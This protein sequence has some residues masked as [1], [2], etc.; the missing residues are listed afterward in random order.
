M[1]K[2]S[3]KPSSI[4][5]FLRLRSGNKKKEEGYEALNTSTPSPSDHS[6]TPLPCSLTPSPDHSSAPD[7]SSS[8]SIDHS[9]GQ[10]S[11]YRTYTP[12]PSTS[13]PSSAGYTPSSEGE[14]RTYTSVSSEGELFRDDDD[15]SS[16]GRV[17]SNSSRLS[18]TS[19]S[20]AQSGFSPSPRSSSG[21]SGEPVLLLTDPELNQMSEPVF[22][23]TLNNSGLFSAIK[24][25]TRA[26]VTPIVVLIPRRQPVIHATEAA[27]I[28]ALS[29]VTE[30]GMGETE[31]AS[32][33]V[34]D[35]A[36]IEEVSEGGLI[37]ESPE[38]G[39]T[40]TEEDHDGIETGSPVEI[41]DR[42]LVETE[43]SGQSTEEELQNPATGDSTADE[44]L[45]EISSDIKQDSESIEPLEVSSSIERVSENISIS[46]QEAPYEPSSQ[47]SAVVLTAIDESPVGPTEESVGQALFL[48]ITQQVFPPPPSP[49]PMV[50]LVFL[51]IFQARS[52]IPDILRSYQRFKLHDD[53]S[54]S[55]SDGSGDE[56]YSESATL[57]P[58]T[59]DSTANS[60]ITTSV[61][62][63]PC[64]SLLSNSTSC[65]SD[66]E[67]DTRWSPDIIP[68]TYFPAVD[69]HRADYHHLDDEGD[70]CFLELP[71]SVGRFF[72]NDEDYFAVINLLNKWG[73]YDVI[74]DGSLT[75]E[76]ISRDQFYFR[77]S[78]EGTTGS[79]DTVMVEDWLPEECP[80]I[81]RLYRGYER[82]EVLQNN[83]M[84]QKSIFCCFCDAIHVVEL[85]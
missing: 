63:T 71:E 34:M 19:T 66:S 47:E 57:C 78:T 35:Y 44:E 36:T 2:S 77:P 65:S 29:E 25:K 53:R 28:P 58:S 43:P 52:D 81:S 56:G 12:S 49:T 22:D 48:D 32:E 27:R 23:I 42:A 41:I 55:C 64:C 46:A 61:T 79:V 38:D 30:I 17:T 5:R 73:K 13:V 33:T 39:V 37:E 24:S 74:V 84:H 45:L 15:M 31:R 18:T 54:T 16:L 70:Y 10:D 4:I 51:Q 7:P 1:P 6:S 67:S 80:V 76:G 72:G 68:I 21:S 40:L 83:V 20:S 26:P 69:H 85:L 75:V 14:N 50:D 9:P 11:A 3:S 62:L 82:G 60:N 59:R 8:L